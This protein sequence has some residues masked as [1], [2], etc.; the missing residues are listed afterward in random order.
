MNQ[1]TTATNIAVVAP[2]PFGCAIGSSFLST[3]KMLEHSP[4]P[5]AFALLK[6]RFTQR[7]VIHMFRDED[8]L[9]TR[10]SEHRRVDI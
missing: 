9:L 1:F 3:N 10:N 4:S 2:P 6:N 7:F 8:A 5:N